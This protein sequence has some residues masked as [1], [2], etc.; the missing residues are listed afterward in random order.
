MVDGMDIHDRY[1]TRRDEVIAAFSAAPVMSHER[2]REDLDRVV[3]ASAVPSVL[4]V[5][6]G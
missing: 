3:D 2:L 5:D 6:R 4:D 1:F